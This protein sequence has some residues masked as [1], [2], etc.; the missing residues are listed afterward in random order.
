MKGYKRFIFVFAAVFALYLLA[1]YNRPKPIDW[2]VS[3]SAQDKNPYGSYI[4]YQQLQDLFPSAAITSYRL[5]VYDQLNDTKQSNTAYLLLEPELSLGEQDLNELMNYA[6]TGNYVFLSSAEVSRQILDSLR[7]GLSKKVSLKNA[8]SIRINFTNPELRASHDYRFNRF[9][10]D[11]F[12]EKFDT[13]QVVVLG[14]NQ[15]KDAN[16]IKVPFG[17]GAFFIHANPICFTN[18]FMLTRDNAAYTAK[19]LS[20]I[21]KDVTKIYWDE[22]YKLGQEGSS[23]PMR[24]VWNNEY[25]AWAFRIAFFTLLLFVLFEMKRR[26]R[27]IPVIP[28][29]RNSSLDFVETVGDV[30]FN[31]HDNRNI[32]MKKIVYL[33]E[34]IR[35]RF[36][37][38]TS[39][40]DN[41]FVSVL[42]KKTGSSEEETQ[43]LVNWID[44]VQQGGAVTDQYLLELNNSIETFYQKFK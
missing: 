33:L 8:D 19:A 21:P 38:Q 39:S 36:F 20:Y 12:V 7:I 5:P 4:L 17:E 14:T 10:I 24:F 34:T 11:E 44:Y 1:E 3:L 22:Y 27:V 30:Y 9:T 43:A 29:L 15:Y 40:L 2:N 28:P 37:M 31:K 13:A 18:Y 25:F 16:F 32:A 41:E 35:T 6:V 26:Q 23:S 42:A